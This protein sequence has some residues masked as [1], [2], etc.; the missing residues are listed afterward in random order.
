MSCKPHVAAWGALLSACKI[1]GNAEMAECAAKRIFELQL[2]NASAYVLLSTIYATAGNRRLYENVEQKIQEQCL[3]KQSGHYN[4]RGLFCDSNIIANN[5]ERS[6][7]KPAVANHNSSQTLKLLRYHNIRIRTIASP[8]Q[9]RNLIQSQNF[10]IVTVSIH[11][12]R[13]T[14]HQKLFATHP[15]P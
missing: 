9:L 15:S 12:L 13:L 2:E 6:F 11:C 7:Q 4:N 14:L 5:K 8:S 3:K 1:H 10:P